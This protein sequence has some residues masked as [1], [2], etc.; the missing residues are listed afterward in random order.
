MYYRLHKFCVLVKGAQNGA[1][2]NF[3]TGKVHSINQSAIKLL[4]EEENISPLLD[5]NQEYLAFFEKLCQMGLGSFYLNRP[6]EKSNSRQT[7]PI[8]NLDFF[9]LEL[10]PQ[11][12]NKCLHCYSSSSPSCQESTVSLDRWLKLIE[13]GAACGASA[14]QLI[15]GEPLLFPGWQELV[16]KAQETGFET[17]EI[18]TNAT[19]IDEKCIHFFQEHNVS[20]ATTIY[21]AREDIHDSVTRNPG[22]FT[23]TMGAIT[24][25]LKANIP[26][27]IASIIMK[28]NERE[29]ENIVRLLEELGV[30]ATPPD[31]IR[32]TGRGENKNLVPENYQKPP[33]QP[34]FYTDEES[35]IRMHNYHSCLAG[36]AAITSNGD[37]IPC[38]FA[39]NQICGNILEKSFQEIIAGEALQKCWHTTKDLVKKCQDCEYRYACSDCRPL[40]QG[41]DWEKNWLAS[42][43]D[44]S[45]NPYTGEWE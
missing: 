6:E 40:A 36:V 35:F 38:I 43:P 8:Q 29:A 33:I 1:I 20:I 27:R 13:E 2:Y 5:N 15:G 34:P 10:T 14:L 4:E 3:Q 30:E 7:S 42:P 31:V 28:E 37:I 45:Y 24:N 26:L 41:K 16:I 19:L 44:C 9:W 39:R 32:P 18:F 23:K 17:I 21:A 12:N 22:S 25:L 11:C